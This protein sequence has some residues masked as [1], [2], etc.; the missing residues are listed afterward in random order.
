LA[1]CGAY[2]DASSDRAGLGDVITSFVFS[3]AFFFVCAARRP[4][5]HANGPA[6]ALIKAALFYFHANAAHSTT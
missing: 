5:A 3:L 2:P 1:K 6:A 4:D